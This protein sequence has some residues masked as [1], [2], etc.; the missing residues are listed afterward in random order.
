DHVG[1]LRRQPFLY[2]QTL[3]IGLHHARKLADA[4]NPSARE[5]GYPGATNDRRDVMFAMTFEGNTAQRDH[6]VI[7]LGFLEGPLKNES[8]VLDVACE[9]LL[10][11]ARHSRRSIDQPV[12]LWI[13]AGPSN[14]GPYGRFDIGPTGPDCVTVSLGRVGFEGRYK[15]MHARIHRI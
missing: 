8:R 2:L 4:D 12:T 10:E 3:G 14:N 5:I 7:T 9:I 11:R 13:V 6:F 15:R 1:N